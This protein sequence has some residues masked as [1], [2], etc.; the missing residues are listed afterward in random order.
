[1]S[2]AVWSATYLCVCCCVY[3]LQSNT[4]LVLRN[5]YVNCQSHGHVRGTQPAHVRWLFH[6]RTQTRSTSAIA[7]IISFAGK[8]P[9]GSQFE[10]FLLHHTLVFKHLPSRV[11][12]LLLRTR[13]RG[14]APAICRTKYTCGCDKAPTLEQHIDGYRSQAVHQ[15]FKRQAAQRHTHTF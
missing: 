12:L 2:R 6:M 13:S 7:V 10:A 9:A 5:Q 8:R 14:Q 11:L 4:R 15:D 1:M 3:D